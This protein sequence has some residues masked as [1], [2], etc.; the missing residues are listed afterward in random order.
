LPQKIL[1]VD[2]ES[3]I[4]ELLGMRLNAA[5]FDVIY[6]TN[7]AEAIEQHSKFQPDLILL[8]INLPTGGSPLQDGVEV[9]REIRTRSDVAI[10]MLTA[11]EEDE[12]A[13]TSYSLGADHYVRKPIDNFEML[14]GR[15]KSRLRP[16]GVELSTIITIGPLVIDV[17]GHEVH[18]GEEAINLTPL[19]F[20]LLKTLAMNPKKVYSRTELLTEVWNYKFKDDARLVNVHVQ[21]LRSKV[22][23]DPADPK[24]VLTVRGKGYRACSN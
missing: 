19:E 7:T 1:V 8:D 11:R 21:R 13:L 14:L 20:D 24:I 17:V 15:I 22:E 23:D 18:K 16:R 4:R 12:T 3:S 9:L 2:D 6:A 5:G 10:I